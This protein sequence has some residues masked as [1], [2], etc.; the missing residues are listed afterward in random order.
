MSASEN[1]EDECE[2]SADDNTGGEGKVESE[3]ALLDV[4][5]ARQTADVGDPIGKQKADA[6]EDHDDPEDNNE[7]ADGRHYPLCG[8][9]VCLLRNLSCSLT[10][11]PQYC[12][13]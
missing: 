12:C 1:P 4:Y 2:K 9:W 5:V 8:C 7:L 13:R 11:H 10:M 6:Y 3:I